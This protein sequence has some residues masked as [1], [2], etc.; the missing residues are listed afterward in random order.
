MRSPLSYFQKNKKPR[1]LNIFEMWDLYLVNHSEDKAKIVPRSLQI[2][3]H[4]EIYTGKPI[5][6]KI[7][8]YFNG[9]DKNLYFHFQKF[10]YGI[11]KYGN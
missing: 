3:Y 1:K 9:L 7:A 2:L 11:V 5:N 8:L 10:I 6:D 4:P